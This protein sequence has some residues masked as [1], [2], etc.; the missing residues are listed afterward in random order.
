MSKRVLVFL[1]ILS[2]AGCG[3]DLDDPEAAPSQ[4]AVTMTDGEAGSV[5][6]LVNY[7]GTDQATLDETIGLDSRAAAGIIERRNGADG[8]SPSADDVLFA[9]I[10]E[11]D[12]VP[13][14]GDVAFAKLQQYAAA[15]PAPSS[16]SV[17]GVYFLGW[18]AEA[19][20]WGVNQAGVDELD[21][22]AA[23]DGRAASN[24]VD[25]GPYATVTA[26]G[27]VGYVGTS[28]LE[29]LRRYAPTWWARLHAA[30][31]A[32]ATTVHDGVSFDEATAATALAIANEATREQLLAHGVYST[33]A[34]RI[35]EHRPYGGLAQVA[36]VDG[37]G[38]ATMQALADYARSGA[39][40]SPAD[41]FLLD[42]AALA[43][44]SQ[45]VKE[46]LWE[47]EGFSRDVA[48]LVG[49]NEAKFGEVMHALEAEVD[50]CAAPL[51]GTVYASEDAARDAIYD[52]SNVKHNVRTYGWDYLE[53]LGVSP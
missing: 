10:G 25:A 50:R 9:D 51:A 11:L 15:H 20:I 16:E 33:G 2:L 38:T 46:G 29:A 22:G 23:L 17:E 30:A 18:E 19:V 53:S 49:W 27:P 43:E 34:T 40:I 47:D 24:L 31:P 13:Y 21:V 39:W 48:D 7:P 42:A 36:A 6:G 32:P 26:M 4:V 41:G 14:V 1:P 8:V 12:D 35:V 28:A 45:R 52:A 37:V 5:L 44:L 3:A